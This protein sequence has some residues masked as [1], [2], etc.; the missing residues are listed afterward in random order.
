LT[1]LHRTPQ[2]SRLAAADK[3]SE[4]RDLLALIAAGA[5]LP[6]YCGLPMQIPGEK[7]V[8]EPRHPAARIYEEI[9]TRAIAE[10]YPELMADTEYDDWIEVNR[11]Y[12]HFKSSYVVIWRLPDGRTQWGIDPAVHHLD[13]DMRTMACSVA[14]SIESEAKALQALAQLLP[15]HKFKA[16]LLSGMFLETSKRSGTMYVFRKLRPTVALSMKGDHP[17]I[18]TCLCMHPIGYYAGSWAGSM[19]PTDD[20]LAH[21]LLMRGDEKMFW[22]RSN[23]IPAW[24][25]G[26]GL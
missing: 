23:Q 16:Y 5:E 25:P 14:W 13:Q 17:R 18:L 11:F 24:N 9:D 1:C 26:A 8:L 15:H 12:S 6:E 21:L 4:T 2:Q 22:R 7:L 3:F 20:V 10:Q 19:C